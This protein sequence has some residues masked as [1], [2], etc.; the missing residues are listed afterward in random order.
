MARSKWLAGPL[1]FVF[2]AGSCSETALI[3]PDGFLLTGTW[4]GENAGL[5]ATDSV[6]HLHIGCTFG[7]V[8]GRLALNTGHEFSADGNYVLR[9]YPVMVGPTL[10]ARFSG[11]LSGRILTVTVTVNDTVEKKSVELGP[12]RVVYGRTPEL[13]PCPICLVPRVVA[14]APRRG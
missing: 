9:A 1:L 2:L 7:D 14:A 10:P 5:I 6:T 12:V 8:P 4:G 3:S 13:G 11:H